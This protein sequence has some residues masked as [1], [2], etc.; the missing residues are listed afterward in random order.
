[1]RGWSRNISAPFNKNLMQTIKINGE[2]F[3]FRFTYSCL[4]KYTKIAKG[5]DVLQESEVAFILGINKGFE[6][7]GSKRVINA[8]EFEN[9]IDDDPKALKLLTDALTHDM[10]PFGDEEESAQAA[11]G[12][13]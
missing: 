7:S 9:L 5:K 2:D 8:K 6:S 3:P 10:E 1:M 12:K 13:K 11:E 4:K